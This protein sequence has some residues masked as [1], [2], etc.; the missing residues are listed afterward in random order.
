MKAADLTN[1]NDIDANIQT[2]LNELASLYEKRAEYFSG[3]ASSGTGTKRRNKRTRYDD[4]DLS[5]I[6]LSLRD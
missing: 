5:T 3:K 2:L 6:D 4:I 1:V